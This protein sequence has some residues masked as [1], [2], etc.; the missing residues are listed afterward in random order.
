MDRIERWR[1][2]LEHTWYREQAPPL[3]LLPL[4]ASFRAAAGFRRWQYRSGWRRAERVA[5]PVIVVG[6]LAVGGTGKTPLTLWL[7]EFLAAR[8]FRPGVVSRGYGGRVGDGVFAVTAATDPALAGDEPV[9]IARRSGRPVRVGRR[10]TAAARALLAE[11]DTDIVIADDGLQHYALARDIEIAVVDG[12]R[13]FGNGH[14]LPA[15]PLR[16]PPARLQCVDLIVHSGT[17]PAGGHV[18]RL[19]GSEAVNLVDER[20]RRPLAAF[21]GQPVVALAGIGHPDR[22]FDQLRGQGLSITARPFPDHHPFRPEDLSEPCDVPVLMTEK[23][24]VKCRPFAG[25]AHWYVPVT[26]QLP[27]AFGQR[28]ITLIQEKCHGPCPA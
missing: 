20:Q 21:I 25:A 3:W 27:A 4:E 7:I 12:R 22:F 5:A 24:A 11:T 23:D 9:L 8:G 13:G 6:N 1:D 28:L 26:A 17:A 15:G 14:C 18:M 19:E 2:W 10:R 16:E